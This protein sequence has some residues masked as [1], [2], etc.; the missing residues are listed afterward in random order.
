ML[1]DREKREHKHAHAAKALS[2]EK[3]LEHIQAGTWGFGGGGAGTTMTEKTSPELEDSAQDAGDERMDDDRNSSGEDEEGLSD[4]EA[5]QLRSSLFSALGG[6]GKTPA[7]HSQS[8]GATPAAS[9]KRKA[10]AS[11]GGHSSGKRTA[12]SSPGAVCSVIPHVL[13]IVLLLMACDRH[14]SICF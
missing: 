13:S 7:K 6:G 14:S 12:T 10:P 2:N 9:S 8:G 1:T 4:G 3:V 5:P 11:A